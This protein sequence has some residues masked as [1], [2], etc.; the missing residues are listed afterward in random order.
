MKKL[1]VLIL[2]LVV[3]S[4]M[5]SAKTQKPVTSAATLIDGNFGWKITKTGIDKN[6]EVDYK[7]LNSTTTEFYITFQNKTAYETLS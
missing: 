1:I 2:G 3:F 7:V 6:V 5:V 4:C